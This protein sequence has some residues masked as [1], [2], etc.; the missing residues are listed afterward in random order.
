L[1]G[2]SA[3][4][5]DAFVRKYDAAGK[6]L[7]TQQFGTSA[8]DY[9]RSVSVGSYGSVLVAGFTAGD[10]VGTSAG[11]TDAFVMALATP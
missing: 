5:N 9:A 1:V 11:G 3:G 10:L 8:N 6:V 2:T 7:W 4:D